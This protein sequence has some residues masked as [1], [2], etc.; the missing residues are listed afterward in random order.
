MTDKN[1]LGIEYLATANAA[2]PVN[3]T[4]HSYFNL[5]GEG[6]GDIL[7]HQ[8]MM[9]AGFFTP[10]DET[11]IPT[12]EIRPVKG[13]PMDFTTPTA[14]GK[15]IGLDDEQL[16]LGNGY[17]HNWVL[18]HPAGKLGMAATV[19]DPA[20]GRIME[21]YTTQPGLQLYTANWLDRE[22]G[23]GGKEYGRHGAFCL[24]TQHF[25]DAVNKSHFPSTIFHPGKAYSHRCIYKFSIA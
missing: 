20:S 8:L 13:T 10:V 6:S 19:S 12:G 17:D 25:P 15:A 1:E 14:I 21:V 3:L 2:T 16:R 22:K 18:D 11:L 24:E 5:A 7:D 4:G 9:K 23:K